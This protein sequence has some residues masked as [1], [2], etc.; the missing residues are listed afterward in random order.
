MTPATI[1]IDAY[2]GGS[3]PDEVL[4]AAAAAS[5]RS[6]PRIVLV[7]EM[8][9]MQA[10]LVETG[11]DPMRLR[12]V[13]GGAPFPRATGDDLARREAATAALPVAF[14]LLTSGEADALVSASP[15]DVVLQQAARH[16]PAL[17]PGLPVAEAAVFPTMPRSSGDDP[18]ALLLDVSGRRAAEPEMLVAWGRMGAVYARVVTGVRQ[19]Q[20]ALLCTGLDAREGPPEVVAAHAGLREVAELRFVGNMRAVDIPRGYADVVVTDGF[21]GHAVRGLLEAVTDLTVEAARY[22]WKAKLSWRIGL[23]L[24]SKG[25]GQLKR[26]SDFQQYGGAPVL[27]LS[28]PV[29]IAAPESSEQAIH[30]AIRL[31]AKCVRRD[32]VGQLREAV[33]GQG[34][35]G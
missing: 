32:L 10:R 11:Y 15:H 3:A 33:G 34:D 8:A 20:V 29:L 9:A 6:G 14:G 27:G 1:A 21:T 17:V 19:P 18:F 5:L 35:A 25:V 2:G 13:D 28:H 12:L 22:A 4:R 7:G 31:A 23:R 26:V 30:N 16:L 24:L